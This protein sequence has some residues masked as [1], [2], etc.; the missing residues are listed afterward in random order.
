MKVI[1]LGKIPDEGKQSGKVCT[2]EKI[3]LSGKLPEKNAKKE[4]CQKK[5]PECGKYQKNS[6]KFL[7]IRQ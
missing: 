6:S 5:L 7:K 3:T 2:W 4:K 1:C